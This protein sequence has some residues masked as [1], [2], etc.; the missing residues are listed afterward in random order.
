VSPEVATKLM[1]QPKS[2]GAAAQTGRV[3]RSLSTG[4]SIVPPGPIQVAR[5]D[6]PATEATIPDLSTPGRSTDDT[7]SAA[8]VNS[9]TTL[10][11]VKAGLQTTLEAFADRRVPDA[12]KAALNRDL[13]PAGQQSAAEISGLLDN[14]TVLAQDLLAQGP[15]SDIEFADSMDDLF[16]VSDWFELFNLN[17]DASPALS[18]SVNSALAVPM[19][20]YYTRALLAPLV[21]VERVVS[22]GLASRRS[23]RANTE[24]VPSENARPTP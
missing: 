9:P 6:L 1:G 10:A 4:A 2:P 17:S 21:D 22:P 18:N 11:T 7:G 14:I 3:A 24:P 8:T 23:V 13:T 15:L 5:T 20:I 16:W 19:D 12:I